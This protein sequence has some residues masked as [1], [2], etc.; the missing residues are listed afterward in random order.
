[1]KKWQLLFMPHT[2]SIIERKLISC[3]SKIFSLLCSVIQHKNYLTGVNIYKLRSPTQSS[4]PTRKKP[5][6]KS[7]TRTQTDMFGAEQQWTPSCERY[8]FPPKCHLRSSGDN[9]IFFS[10][11]SSSFSLTPPSLPLK[12]MKR[13][14]QKCSETNGEP[15]FWSFWFVR[16]EGA[17]QRTNDDSSHCSSLYHYHPLSTFSFQ[18]SHMCCVSL[19]CTRNRARKG[20]KKEKE[21]VS[22]DMIYACRQFKLRA[23]LH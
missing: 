10:S 23:R 20:K 14:D 12:L 2:D 1:M 22:C 18:S 5:S 11:S 21:F 6:V 8:L 7:R 3:N 15:L 4:R 13:N 9:S 19:L 17:T 16:L